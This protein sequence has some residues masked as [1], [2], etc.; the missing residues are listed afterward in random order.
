MLCGRFRAEEIMN[1]KNEHLVELTKELLDDIELNRQTAECLLLKAT[2]LARFEGPKEIQKWLRFELR[3]YSGSDEIAIKYMGKTGRWINKDEHK[4]YWSPLAEIESYINS[5]KLKLQSMRTPNISGDYAAFAV[6]SANQAMSNTSANIS[7]FSGIRSRVL[8]LLHSYVSD[9]Y[10]AKLFDIQAESIFETYKETIDLKLTEECGDILDKIPSVINRLSE[11]DPESISQAL[12]TC[13]RIIDAFANKIFPASEDVFEING[14]KLS[15]TND[16][17]QNR[18]NVYVH[19]KTDSDSIRKK[20]RQN[21][22]NLYDRVSSAVHNDVTPN[23]AK[24]L[25]LNT[26]LLIGEIIQF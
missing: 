9:F 25:F 22:S 15:L 4:G 24:A 23:E 20:I 11:N 16:K 14:N 5:E 13:R 26:Y 21:L 12:L 17:V 2:R 19:T 1:T 8:S 6:S 3:G 18:I 10:Y 7:K